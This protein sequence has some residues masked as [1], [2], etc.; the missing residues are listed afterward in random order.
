MLRRI[1]VSAVLIS[2]VG[3]A[4]TIGGT[5]A[6]FSDV[7][8][9]T[10]NTFAAGAIDLTVDN[11]SYYNLNKCANVATSGPAVWQWV[12]TSTYPVPGSACTT[13][14][15]ASDLGNGLL[16]FNFQDLK[17]DDEGE[18]TISLHVGTNNAYACMDV[19][20]TSNDDRSS[21]EPELGTGDATEDINNTWD[22]EL[23]QN[24]Q[25]LWW[26]D[27]GDNVFEQGENV[28]SS[29]VQTLFNLATSSPFSVALADS[30]HN[31]WATTTN[32]FQ[33]I[34]GNTTVYIAK[35]FCFGTLTSQA[36]AQDGLGHTGTN[37]PQSRGTGFDCSGS[38]LGNNTQTD[39]VT[40]DVAFRAVQSRSNTNF[41]CEG[42]LRLGKLTVT[43]IVNNTNG[44]NNTIPNFQLF[45][46]NGTVTTPVTSSISTTVAAGN[47]SVSETGVSGYVG[48]YSGDCDAE[49]NVVI[50]PGDDKQCTIT[51]NDLPA[52]IT[53]IKV[54]DSG[55]A[56]PS[57]FKM[58]VD[59]VLVPNTTSISV[60]SNT[61]HVITEDAKAG[62]Q[63]VSITGSAQCP[64]VLGG[65]ATL[66]EGQA[67]TC[68]IHNALAP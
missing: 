63:F 40:L 49:G 7:E 66:N 46:D 57:T 33:P 12:G 41:L 53:L 20:L 50:N 31:V 65:T 26:A 52:N 9:S 2:I 8:T 56:D 39:G 47:Y 55:P 29:G 4:A 19:T 17:P 61:P 48:S 6:F 14:W 34:P 62:Y 35:S 37:G 64:A 59:G 18:D 3:T 5:G 25:M 43:K 27:D 51:N 24:I 21:N 15:D 42:Q 36:I 60:T 58:R 1:L 16:F 28:I 54:V 22:G 30:T 32:S 68:T 38:G 13:S 11:E 44:G 23:A 67:I 45:I 10:G